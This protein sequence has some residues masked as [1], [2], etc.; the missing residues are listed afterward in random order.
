MGPAQQY[1]QPKVGASS[2]AGRSTDVKHLFSTPKSSLSPSEGQS[3]D[4]ANVV[5]HGERQSQSMLMYLI[6]LFN[7]FKVR[8]MMVCSLLHLE[9]QV[10]T[11]LYVSF[12]VLIH[13]SKKRKKRKR[14]NFWS[15]EFFSWICCMALRISTSG[16]SSSSRYLV[17][18]ETGLPRGNSMWVS[19]KHWRRTYFRNLKIKA[20][21][22]DAISSPTG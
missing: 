9:W 11:H 15:I 20:T 7:S 17:N 19:Q 13:N 18:H 12:W 10:Y 4:F 22:V 8:W 2:L 14:I 3:Y 5:M 6:H 21:H 1:H 16:S